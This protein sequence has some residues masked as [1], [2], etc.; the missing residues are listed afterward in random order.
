MGCWFFRH[1]LRAQFDPDLPKWP[2][3]RQLP[4]FR[5]LEA[6]VIG[7]V[8]TR[9]HLPLSFI[10]QIYPLEVVHCIQKPR[11]PKFK[12]SHDDNDL[13]QTRHI[14]LCFSFRSE[15][16]PN[17]RGTQ[18]SVPISPPL[19]RPLAMLK[20]PRDVFDSPSSSSPPSTKRFQS[21]S[22][23]YASSSTFSSPLKGFATPGG[24]SIPSDS[25]SNPFSLKVAHVINLPIGLRTSKHLELRFQLVRTEPATS[26]R[27]SKSTPYRSLRNYT[28]RT[29]LVPPNYSFK[30]LYKLVL[31]LFDLDASPEHVFEVQEDVEMYSALANKSG[32]VKKGKTM[33]KLSRN[34]DDQLKAAKVKGKGKGKVKAPVSKDGVAWEGE[35]DYHLGRVWPQGNEESKK[36]I[37]YVRFVSLTHPDYN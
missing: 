31:F 29:V 23:S 7:R 17:L 14:D 18:G 25:P 12:G 21:G 13:S 22:S 1:I 28:Y 35:D 34:F 24:H 16:Y 5:L 26:K 27:V 37:L 3:E 19:V 10:K 9:Y 4:A 32:Y 11:P 2:V 15:P 6:T 8:F 20:R 30:L 33:V 36:A